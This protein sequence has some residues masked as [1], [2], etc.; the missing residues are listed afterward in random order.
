MR[1]KRLAQEHNTMYLARARTWTARSRDK[2]TNHKAT[3]PPTV[4]PAAEDN[5]SQL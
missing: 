4:Q 5:R 2:C 1:V 3:M